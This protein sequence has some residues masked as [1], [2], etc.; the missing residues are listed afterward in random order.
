MFVASGS[1][2]PS[3]FLNLMI[4]STSS[5]LRFSFPDGNTEEM[6]LYKEFKRTSGNDSTAPSEQQLLKTTPRYA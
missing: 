2:I 3:P 5:T 1:S 4:V 6:N